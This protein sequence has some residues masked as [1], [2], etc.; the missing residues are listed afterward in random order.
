MNKN[1]MK[2]LVGTM[3]NKLKDAVG[4][5]P[6]YYAEELK[7]SFREAIRDNVSDLQQATGK[8]IC[9]ASKGLLGF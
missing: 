9:S 2:T 1:N 8:P 6:K 4:K 3:K 7:S 5:P